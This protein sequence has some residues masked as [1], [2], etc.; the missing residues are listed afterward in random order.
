MT[1]QR[2]GFFVACTLLI[3]VVLLPAFGITSAKAN[4]DMLAT[5]PASATLAATL[6]ATPAVS[7]APAAR[8]IWQAEP[9][10]DKQTGKC[11]GSPVNYCSQL[12][13]LT[14]RGRNFYWKGQELKPYL[15]YRS[16]TNIYYYSGR[17]GLGDG[18]IKLT[19]Q[20]TSP[21]TFKATQVLKLFNEPTCTHTMLFT[22]SFLR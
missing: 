22:G 4:A 16:K 19:L 11:S 2:L 15:L 9:Q 5:A 12:V 20:F 21:T 17:N 1:N 13:A 8:T 10:L 18:T 14:A 7:F 3:L 6:A